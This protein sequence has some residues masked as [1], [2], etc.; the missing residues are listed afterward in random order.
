MNTEPDHADHPLLCTDLRSLAG[1]QYL[2]SAAQGSY[3]VRDELSGWMSRLAL[4]ERRAASVLVWSGWAVPAL[5]R[6]PAYAAAICDGPHFP[7]YQAEIATC[8]DRS[9][10]VPCARP[11][12]V[13]LDET[14]LTRWIGGAQVAAEQ[15]GH[16]A[17]L[18]ES[19]HVLVQIVPLTSPVILPTE[20]VSQLGLVEGYL[21]T[22][23]S[24]G[25]TYSTGPIEGAK[26]Q[27]L[28]EA[29]LAAALPIRQSLDRLR[30]ARDELRGRAI[31]RP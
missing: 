25:A 21:Y 14:I 28:L 16:L 24:N 17:E 23:E 27:R 18:T 26:R 10:P 2:V 1:L 3:L 8:P 29:A 12:T 15:L 6:T 7:K 9:V 5:V 11:V 20:A 30:Q 31:R 13:V 19:G 22:E 4:C